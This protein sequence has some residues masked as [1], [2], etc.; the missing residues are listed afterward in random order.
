MF[1]LC[2]KLNILDKVTKLK[3]LFSLKPYGKRE[4]RETDFDRCYP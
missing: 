3:I 2:V 4:D 1:S